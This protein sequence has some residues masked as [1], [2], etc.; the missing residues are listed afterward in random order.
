MKKTPLYDAIRKARHKYIYYTR[1]NPPC[2]Y[3]TEEVLSKIKKELNVPDGVDCP[4]LC[5]MTIVLVKDGETQF[6]LSV[7]GEDYLDLYQRVLEAEKED[8]D[9]QIQGAEDSSR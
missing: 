6:P 9:D 2:I 5:G 3:L 7:G 8:D 1:K 4:T